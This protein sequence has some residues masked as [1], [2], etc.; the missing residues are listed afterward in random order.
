M[1]RFRGAQDGGWADLVSRWGKAHT[2]ARGNTRERSFPF[3]RP[4]KNER[5]PRVGKNSN[6]CPES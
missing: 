4:D 6:A 2:N 5:R 1:A 3:Y